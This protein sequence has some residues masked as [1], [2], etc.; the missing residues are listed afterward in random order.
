MHEAIRK[1]Y[2]AGKL[3]WPAVEH[4][5]LDD[6]ANHV[7]RVSAKP[8]DLGRHGT[9]LFL[10]L[11]CGSND[12]RAVRILERK[13]R[14]NLDIYLERS[15]FDEPTRQDVLQQLWLH[16]CAGPQPRILTYAA[17][18]SLAAW[19]KV[20]AL[21]F[22]IH[23]KPCVPLANT[24]VGE[25]AICNFVAENASP[26]LKLTVE[27][28]KPLFQSALALAMSLLSDRDVTILRLFFVEGVSS[29]NI[30]KLYGVHRATSARWITEIRRRILES[31]QGTLATDYGVDSSEFESLAFLMRSQLH[32]SFG[33]LFGAA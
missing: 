29:E 7:H 17:R 30:A 33:R 16:L 24:D 14:S 2:L 3:E 27:Y 22:A 25:I 1:A 13:H 11:C 6:F 12:G 9:D 31:V 32:L 10:A 4:R 15:G 28:A 8:S 20:A 21:R 18:A 19:T 5:T 26:E 23:M